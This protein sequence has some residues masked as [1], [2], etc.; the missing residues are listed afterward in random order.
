VWQK[1]VIT[2]ETDTTYTLRI[3]NPFGIPAEQLRVFKKEDITV[4]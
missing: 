2:D 1:G 4:I 3:Y